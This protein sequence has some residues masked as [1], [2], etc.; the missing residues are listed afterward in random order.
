MKSKLYFV[1]ILTNFTNTVFYIGVT[2]NLTIRAYQHKEKVA[3]GFTSKY[4]VDKL[5]YAEEYIDIN[6]AIR[7]EKQL[8]NWH[9]QWKLNL[10]QK[11]NPEFR[12]ISLQ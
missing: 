3:D 4:N 8:K 5:V 11:K 12:E 7:R 2:Q 10:I 9:R 1:Y 6:E